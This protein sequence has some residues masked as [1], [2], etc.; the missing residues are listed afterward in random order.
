MAIIPFYTSFYYY[1][2]VDKLEDE[3]WA[4]KYGTL[5]DGLQL[6][7]EENKRKSALF[8]PFFFVIRRLAFVFAVIYMK[9]FLW[10]QIMTMFTCC[11]IMVIYLNYVWPFVDDILTKLELFNEIIS[12]M[13][14]YVMFTFTDWVP[15]AETRYYIGWVFITII[16]AHL[17]THMFLL[18]ADSVSNCKKKQKEKKYKARKALYT[19]NKP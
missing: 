2:N 6:S 18:I 16:V 19:K 5:Y 9:D 8:F 1:C 7:T 12:I 11:I 4:E 13:L 14:L 15:L 3:K 17:M 10:G